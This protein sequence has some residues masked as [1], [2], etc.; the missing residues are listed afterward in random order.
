MG[1]GPGGVGVT[2]VVSRCFNKVKA[3]FKKCNFLTHCC[4]THCLPGRRVSIRI[5]L[6]GG[7]GG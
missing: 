7:S 6:K 2:L 3:T 4:V 1:V 5:L